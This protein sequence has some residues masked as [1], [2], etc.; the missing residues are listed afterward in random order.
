[1][2]AP[3]PDPA[4]FDHWIEA[5]QAGRQYWRDV[6]AFRE[7]LAVLAWRDL[8]VRY[9]QTVAGA[10]WAIIQ[11][12]LTMLIMTLIFGRVAGLPSIGDAPYAIMVFAALLPWQFFASALTNATQS[13]VGNA[14]LISKIYFP[15][16]LIPAAAIFVSLVDFLVA[17]VI[18]AA[19]M[20]WYQYPPTWR[21]ITLP[22]FA[23]LAAVTALG[24][25]LLI[26]AL[27]VRFRDFRFIV[28]FVVQLGMYISPVAYSSEVVREK[29]G[30][31]G[32][33][34]YSMNPLVG[35]IDGFRWAI[36]G[37]QATFFTPANALS[38]GIA[39]LL[40]FVGLTYFRRT[41]RTFAD[42]I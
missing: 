41:E 18:L 3:K 6:F 19:L 42:L 28:P 37:G 11:P 35:V 7:L 27:T 25:G 32:F 30:E 15:R 14:N 38:L 21:L 40:L 13:L 1:M 10:T 8:T 31:V 23:T 20:L 16:V 12:L 17:F 9:K 2:S 22:I 34:I 39:F 5:G 4:T 24:P 26:T 29:F 36:L 33:F